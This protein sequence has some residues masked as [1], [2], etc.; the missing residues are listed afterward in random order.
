MQKNV[1]EV[2]ARTWVPTVPLWAETS[3]REVSYALCDDRRTLLW[4]AN[5]RAVEY[6]P[7]LVTRRALGPAHAPGAR[8]RPARAAGRRSGWP[9]GP[10]TWSGRR[11]PTRAW[12]ARSRPAGPRACTCSCP[13]DDAARR[14]RTWPPRPA[15]S[16]PGPSGSTPSSPRPRSSGRTAAAR[17]SSTRP[18]PAGPPWSPPT[19]RASGRARRCRS[20]WPGTTWTGSRPPTSPC[21]P[22]PAAGRRRRPVGG[23]RCPRRSALPADLIEEGRHDPGRPGAGH[24]RGQAP[25]PG[26]APS[27][28]RRRGS[29]G[30][31]GPW[32]LILTPWSPSCR[33]PAGSA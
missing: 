30:T 10:R 13:I 18:G 3:K 5:Q 4:F 2:H 20:R 11:W 15:R 1:P 17:C 32:P 8:P 12:P 31:L 24:A 21:A 14:S 22:R 28:G 25:G 26:P 33:S 19:A 9:S 29:N 6:H 27:G 23:R 7:T 16:P